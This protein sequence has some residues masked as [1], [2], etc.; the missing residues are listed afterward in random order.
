MDSGWTVAAVLYLIGAGLCYQFIVVCFRWQNDD[1][2]RLS[3]LVMWTV[4]ALWP[5]FVFRAMY[6]TRHPRRIKGG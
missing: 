2:G 1:A 4:V 5:A 6:T 3:P